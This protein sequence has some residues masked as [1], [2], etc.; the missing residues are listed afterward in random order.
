MLESRF[1][2]FK[3]DYSQAKD[4]AIGAFVS[5]DDISV[6]GHVWRINYYP[7]WYSEDVN[8][9]YSA[10]FLKL[11]DKSKNVKAVFEA[12]MMGKDGK[13]CE[14]PQRMRTI[15]VFPTDGDWG[16]KKFVE[17][18]HL[19]P[20]HVDT[21]GCFTIMCGITVLPGDVVDDALDVPPPDMGV[22]LGRLLDSGDGF[23][24]SFVV[25][26]ETFPAHR[27]VLAAR[28]PVFKAQLLGSMAE[29]AM[30]YS[31]TLHDIA[32]ATFRIMLR[33]IYTDALPGDEELGDSPTEMLQDLLAMADL[34]AL[35]RLKTL[36]AR[37]LWDG[38]AVDTVAAT[39]A[40]A[41]MFN[42]AE[43]KNKCF[44]FFAEGETLKKAELTDDFVQLRQKFP[45]IVDELKEKMGTCHL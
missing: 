9:E 29:A 5:S 42:C 27:A 30:P 35:E 31:I 10:I 22:H 26:G 40:S 45:S 17:R 11:A 43:L 7:N 39:L 18:S 33:F 32:P 41:E 28:S 6:G 19:L 2:K 14:P 16:W 8:G 21:D 44:A 13:P 24:V 20:D 1:F 37:K 4:M 25:D 23:D 36:C 34:Y 3:L 12:F 15:N 38:L